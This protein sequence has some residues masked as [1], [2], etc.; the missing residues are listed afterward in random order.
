MN[1]LVII[2]SLFLFNGESQKS[3]SGALDGGQGFS[4]IQLHYE[5]CQGKPVISL[6]NFQRQCLWIF[7]LGHASFTGEESFGLLPGQCMPRFGKLN[8]KENWNLKT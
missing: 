8:R 4:T 5:G 6:G 7:S 1:C 3:E 2:S